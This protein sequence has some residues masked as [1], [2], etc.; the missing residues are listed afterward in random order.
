MDTSQMKCFGNDDK[1]YGTK[2]VYCSQHCRVHDTG[3]CTVSNLD[4][5]PLLA[6]TPEEAE[7]EWRMKRDHFASFVYNK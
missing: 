5:I 6:E 1:V 7:K 2:Y 3:W 4:K